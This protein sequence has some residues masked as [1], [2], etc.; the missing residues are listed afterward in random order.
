MK[1]ILKNSL[2]SFFSSKIKVAVLVGFI[3]MAVLFRSKFNSFNNF[4]MTWS[5]LFKVGNYIKGTSIIAVLL[6]T[7]IHM[8]IDVNQMSKRESLYLIDFSP[9]KYNIFMT[10]FI[11]VLYLVALAYPMYKLSGTFNAQDYLFISLVSFVSSL[12]IFAAKKDRLLTIPAIALFEMLMFW[13]NIAAQIIYIVLTIG[14]YI[15][16][17]ISVSKGPQATFDVNLSKVTRMKFFE[18][19]VYMSR[20][21]KVFKWMFATIIFVLWMYLVP[22]KYHLRYKFLDFTPLI[23]LFANVLWIVRGFIFNREDNFYTK[24][25]NHL[26]YVHYFVFNLVCLVLLQVLTMYYSV[27]HLTDFQKINDTYNTFTMFAVAMIV[28][29]LTRR[30]TWYINTGIFILSLFIPNVIIS[31]VGTQ[32]NIWFIIIELVILV[33]L[34]F[35]EFL[36]AQHGKLKTSLKIFK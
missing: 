3:I 26:I 14:L 9:A 1:I 8:I 5:G 23:A 29:V 32:P 4:I 7:V 35:V 22:D 10:L 27:N 31:F 33:G 34:V 20:K 36:I 25:T 17:I 11:Y 6:F 13:N 30:R 16:S 2:R 28:S 24:N 12:L 18:S 19:I 15:Y 21:E